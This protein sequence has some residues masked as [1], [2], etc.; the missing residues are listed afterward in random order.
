MDPFNLNNLGFYYL[1]TFGLNKYT[2]INKIRMERS[3][4]NLNT[5]PP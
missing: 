1:K 5:L 2:Y 3:L 4:W